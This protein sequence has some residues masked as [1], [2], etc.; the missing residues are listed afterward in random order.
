VHVLLG[1]KRRKFECARCGRCGGM[2]VTHTVT[3]NQT[4]T[5]FA[6]LRQLIAAIVR[7]T[8]GE[9]GAMSSGIRVRL[10]RTLPVDSIVF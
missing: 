2:Q 3:S 6:N 9:Y 1:K 10:S 4:D 7:G 8:S 5:R